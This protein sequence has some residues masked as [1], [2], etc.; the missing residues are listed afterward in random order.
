M[1]RG[2]SLL[3]ATLASLRYC[4]RARRLLGRLAVCSDVFHCKFAVRLALLGLAALAAGNSAGCG[5]IARNRN[6]EGVRYFDQGQFSAAQAKF[7]QAVRVN[8]QSADAYYNLA[9]I[10]HRQ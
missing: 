10:A 8:P 9:A 5:L 2:D 7:Q 1:Q 6:A 3:G 4:R